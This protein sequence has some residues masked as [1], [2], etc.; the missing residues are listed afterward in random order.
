MQK[1]FTARHE[2][3]IEIQARDVELVSS[4]ILYVQRFN[5]RENVS[6]LHL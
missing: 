5:Y 6:I 1:G 4:P 2:M 3:K